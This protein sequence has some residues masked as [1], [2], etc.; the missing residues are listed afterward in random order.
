MVKPDFPMLLK[1]GIHK[2]SMAELHSLA[3]APFASQ[4]RDDLYQLFSNWQNAIRQAGV[5][6]VLWIDGSYLT[7]KPEPGDIDCVLWQPQWRKQT[8]ITPADQQAIINLMDHGGVKAVYNLDLY[9]EQAVN[10]DR[11]AYWSGVLG[12][13]HDRTKAKGFAEIA[14]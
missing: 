8:P 9:V 3:V 5:A 13:G 6:G 11:Q 10:F 1:P 7:E 2:L 12:F 4:R 14:L